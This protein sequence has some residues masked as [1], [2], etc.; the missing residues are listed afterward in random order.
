ML[1]GRAS[2]SLGPSR[3]VYLTHLK[4][5]RG[6]YAARVWGGLFSLPP[7]SGSD[8]LLA[9]RLCSARWTELQ[10]AMHASQFDLQSR[11]S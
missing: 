8:A 7:C 9:G 6:G 10:N 4:H 5:S 1:H 11:S 2:P 3:I